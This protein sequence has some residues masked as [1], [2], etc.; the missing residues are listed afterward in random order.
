[1]RVSLRHTAVFIATDW[2]RRRLER[3]GYVAHRWPVTRFDGMSDALTLLKQ[4]GYQP[5]VIVDCGANVGQW[6]TLATRIFP[7]AASHVVEPQPACLATLRKIAARRDRVMIH[8]V[9]VS[10]P[11]TASVRMLG[12]GDGTGTGNFVALPGETGTDQQTVEA[13]TLDEL[14]ADSLQP[15]DRTLL[16]LD[17]EQ[18]ELEVLKGAARLLP[19]VEVV[20][21]ELS[22]YDVSGGRPTFKAVFEH[23]QSRGFEFYDVACLSSRPRDK[24]LRQADM[25]FVH[26]DSA[27][28]K[29][30]NWA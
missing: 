23:L 26:R 16:K 15:S 30:R 13:T 9:A 2:L 17:V 20:L 18:H 14:L 6:L 3:F 8:P 19:L 25:L 4:R 11:E 29:D 24:R 28:L 27:L 22:L 7:D 1:M 21:T 12:G 10:S 5:R